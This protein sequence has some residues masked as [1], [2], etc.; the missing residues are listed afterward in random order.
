M[1]TTIIFTGACLLAIAFIGCVA[2]VDVEQEAAKLLDTDKEFAEASLDRGTAEAFKM[3][4]TEDATIFPDMSDPITGRE[5]IYKHL[6]KGE[7]QY[8]IDW[9]PKDASV[10]A[11]GEI[12]WTWG[13]Y[14]LYRL[15][16]E[17][18]IVMAYG[19]YLD[20]WKKQEDGSWKMYLDM[21]NSSPEPAME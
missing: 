12:G 13:N 5:N 2:T 9:E 7:H 18:E 3:Y 4:I 6:K 1:K 16:G 10:A 17:E 20:V 11:S 21:G 8:L 19:K 14:T 15:K